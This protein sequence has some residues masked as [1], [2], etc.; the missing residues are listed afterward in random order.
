M[1]K[2]RRLPY[3]LW[4]PLVLFGLLAIW[5]SQID[6]AVARYFYHPNGFLPQSDPH[7]PF[8]TA[9]Y[10]YGNLPGQLAGIGA[11]LVLL[12]SLRVQALKKWRR[13]AWVVAITGFIGAGLIVNGIVKEYWNRPRPRQLVEFGGTEQYHA[14]YSPITGHNEVEFK[15]FPSGHAAMGFLFLSFSLVG[16]YERRRALFIGGMFVGLALGLLMS[17][18]RLMQGAHFTS[19]V[20]ASALVMWLTA[21]IACRFV[22]GPIDAVSGDWKR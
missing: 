20:V 16:W 4:L 6:L 1:T 9:I 8:F 13:G 10:K 3:Q 2:T 21:L 22:Y 7:H 18:G 15:S 11:A 19:D 12:L 14:F 5:S 17:Y